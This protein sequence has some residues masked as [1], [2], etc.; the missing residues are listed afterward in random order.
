MLIDDAFTAHLANEARLLADLGR[1]DAATLEPI[2][3]RWL[4]T[5]EG[6]DPGQAASA[7]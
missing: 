4:A 1:Q 3:K 7:R 2:L 6:D 5:L